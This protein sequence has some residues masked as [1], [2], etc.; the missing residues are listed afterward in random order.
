[1]KNTS[2]FNDFSVSTV[3]EKK[4]VLSF[5]L[6]D[7]SRSDL[8]SFFKKL[9]SSESEEM[10]FQMNPQWTVYFNMIS[11]MTTKFFLAKPEAG[12]QIATASFSKT[13]ATEVMNALETLKGG[14]KVSLSS[15]AMVHILSNF[16]IEFT[17]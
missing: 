2:A 4:T 11:G 10:K 17:F 1:M 15:L 13:H 14:D 16:D 3:S 12:L 9:S 8:I 6:T 7:E 5:K